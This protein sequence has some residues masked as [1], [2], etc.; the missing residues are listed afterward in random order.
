MLVM[1]PIREMACQI[2]SEAERFGHHIGIYSVCVYGGASCGPQLR[3]MQKGKHVIVGTLGRLNDFVEQ[4][5]LRLGICTSLVLDEV[6]RML[7]MGFL[8]QIQ[9]VIQACPRERQTMM[10]SATWPK[11]VHK[12]AQ[13]YLTKPMHVQIGSHGLRGYSGPHSHFESRG[14][15]SLQPRLRTLDRIQE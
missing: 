15:C 13:D 5:Q 9:T 12:L 1:A 10:F 14:G 11:D 3:E 4:G 6:D 2:Q 7:G 8:P